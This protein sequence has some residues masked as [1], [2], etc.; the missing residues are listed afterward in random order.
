MQPSVR[1]F[2]IKPRRII[3]KICGL[4]K[5]QRGLYRLAGGKFRGNL[6]Q[7]GSEFSAVGLVDLLKR[8]LALRVGERH[9]KFCRLENAVA[10]G[11]LKMLQVR[12][13]DAQ[14]CG[15]VIDAKV[16]KRSISRCRIRRN[17]FH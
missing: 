13:G 11:G 2:Q 6:P 12:A 7:R 5:F 14:S 4:A 9:Q 17:N 1:R 15:A 10:V 3:G 8:P 16:D